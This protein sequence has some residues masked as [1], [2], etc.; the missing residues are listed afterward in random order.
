MKKKLL[1]ILLLI[2]ILTSILPA[3]NVFAG[4]YVAILYIK[5]VEYQA[6]LKT[7]S[8]ILNDEG[9][10]NSE[11]PEVIIPDGTKRPSEYS[12]SVDQIASKGYVK[13]WIND[14][15]YLKHLYLAYD[16]NN[17]CLQAGRYK[18]SQD[19]LIPEGYEF[20]DTFCNRNDI[21]VTIT[22]EEV[23][24]YWQMVKQPGGGT[25]YWVI[26]IPVKETG[27]ASKAI[28][29]PPVP[30][31]HA[32]EDMAYL[33]YDYKA[34]DFE[35]YEIQYSTKSN[36]GFKT[37]SKVNYVRYGS[38]KGLKHGKTYYFRARTVREIA[39]KRYYSKWT[40]VKKKKV[41]KISQYSKLNI[42]L[43]SAARNQNN[44]FLQDKLKNRLH[45][46][47]NIIFK[48]STKKNGTYKTIKGT[49]H[50]PCMV[51]KLQKK[52]GMKKGKTYYLKA[53]VKV[54]CEDGSYVLVV[55]SAFK[56]VGR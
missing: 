7:T 29:N 4:G 1:S 40:E 44:L 12:Y 50:S 16:E 23:D 28:A 21:G 32:D 54:P 20:D 45:E 6:D 25:V 49:Y 38:V 46:N 47:W 9:L 2:S 48:Y 39:G 33:S 11:N 51:E 18:L 24:K 53:V 3:T 52:A 30:K 5:W 55:T 35:S 8:I 26:E 10:M 15:I 42:W 56:Y 41:N 36:S 37:I 34:P 43:D 17:I 13:E 27:K 19:F 14:N 31:L 22:Q